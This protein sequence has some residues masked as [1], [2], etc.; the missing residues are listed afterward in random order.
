MFYGEKAVNWNNSPK[1]A[2]VSG[3]VI[4]KE[5]FARFSKEKIEIRVNAEH[6][7]NEKKNTTKHEYSVSFENRNH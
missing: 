4:A 2:A 1:A 5:K 3:Q 7:L 6:W